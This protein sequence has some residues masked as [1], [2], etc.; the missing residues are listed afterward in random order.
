MAWGLRIYID[1]DDVLSQTIQALIALLRERT[2]R[3]A[4]YEQVTQFN[5]EVSFGIS[6][7]EFASYMEAA[8]EPGFL[9]A[10][11][12]IEGAAAVLRS[13]DAA[14]HQLNILSGRPAESLAPTRRWLVQQGMPHHH[15]E[16]VDKYGRSPEATP[17]DELPG[18]GY[19]LVIEDSLAM[20]RFMAERSTA[21]V[22][23]LDR[24]WNRNGETIPAEIWDRIERVADWAA[25]A[26][27]V[28]V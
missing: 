22:L 7:A 24:P 10:M 28:D 21:R 23:L 16:M 26:A 18:R 6:G 1:V 13:W 27:A 8:H 25:I 2:G 17:K 14:G 15:V 4:T 5:L 11:E 12:P 19:D 3:V 20:A 9:E